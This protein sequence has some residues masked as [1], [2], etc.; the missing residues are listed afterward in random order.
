MS[1]ELEALNDLRNK[2]CDYLSLS[3]DRQV[4]DSFK[5]IET[6]LKAL[7]LKSLE[8]IKEKGC[9]YIEKALIVSCKNYEE[10]C[11]EMNSG[12]VYSSRYEWKKALKTQEEY[13]LLKGVLDNE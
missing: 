5:L 3:M 4:C 12:R 9:S 8:I 11:F 13:E 1:K 10:Y 2:C 7:E 6:A